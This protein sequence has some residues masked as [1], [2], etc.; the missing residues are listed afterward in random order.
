MPDPTSLGCASVLSPERDEQFDAVPESAFS[1]EI[2][3]TGSQGA[4]TLMRSRCN[5]SFAYISRM[6]GLGNVASRQCSLQ[7]AEPDGGLL[8]RAHERRDLRRESE[9][10]GLVPRHCSSFVEGSVGSRL[11]KP[12]TGRAYVARAPRLPERE[13][14]RG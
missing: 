13:G 5:V 3:A 9:L 14:R 6:R 12:G 1:S 4:R 2:P 10:D 8:E 11:A 7:L